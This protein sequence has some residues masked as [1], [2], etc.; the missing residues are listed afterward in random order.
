[1]SET[2][3]ANEL[4]QFFDAKVAAVQAATADAP[5][6]SFTPNPTSNKLMDFRPVT[7]DDVIAAVH[8]LP[9]KQCSSDPM[10]TKLLKDNIDI[11]APFVV[12]LFNRSLSTG[13]V[14]PVFKD[15]FVTPLLKKAGMDP[16]DVRSYRPISNLSVLSKLLERLVA[17]QLVDYLTSSNLLPNLQSAYRTHHSTETAVLKV[18]SDILRAI[19]NGDLAMLTLLDLSAAFDTV[20]HA[21]LLRRLE[22]SYGIGGAVLDWFRSFLDGRTQYVRCGASRSRRSIIRCGVPQGSVLAAIL[23]L[24]YTADLLRLIEQHQLRPH[25]Y[26][27]DTQIY[28][29]C[30]P[31]STTQLQNQSSQC[32]DDVARWMKSNRLQLNTTKTEVLWCSSV[33]RQHQIPRSGVRIGSDVVVPSASVRDLGIYIDSDVSM[34]THVARTVSS[35][36]AVLRQLRSIRRSVTQPVMQTLVVALVLTRLDYGNATLAGITGQLLAKLQSVLNA[37][38]R[39]IFLSRKY[40]HVTPLLRDLHWLRFPERIDFKLAV[41][42]YKCLNGTA[43]SYLASEIVCVAD[44]ENRRHL[45]S[46]STNELVVPRMRR[47]TIGD[48]AFPVVA[49]RLWNSLPTQVTSSPSITDFKRNLK[50]ELFC[51]G[52]GLKRL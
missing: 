28:G 38:A 32:I 24:L 3:G 50:T 17:K 43:P 21:T 14:P 7:V 11:L 15:A 23:F 48:R 41:L 8:A 40:D 4:H 37:A 33:R 47:S 52:Y 9:N 44:L 29:F 46:A 16:T 45:R 1:L 34:R 42:V 18:L 20:D 36:F 39:L 31:P 10:T 22:I 49:A 12:D 6:P 26:A 2:V 5:T 30:P 35:C 13:S 19:D 25:L 27:D 51:R